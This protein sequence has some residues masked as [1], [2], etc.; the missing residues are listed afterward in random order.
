MGWVL[1]IGS[2]DLTGSTLLLFD[3][4]SGEYDWNYPWELSASIYRLEAVKEA[5]QAIRKEF[6]Q[7][8]ARQLSK[9]GLGFRAFRPCSIPIIPHIYPNIVASILFSIIP[10]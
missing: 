7:D 9:G 8:A 6:G 10:I 4:S 1:G 5:L 2:L 3:R